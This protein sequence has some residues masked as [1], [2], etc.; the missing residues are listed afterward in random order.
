MLMTTKTV[1]LSMTPALTPIRRGTVVSTP[2][3]TKDVMTRT[4]PSYPE[5][6]SLQLS[7][8]TAYS[9]SELNVQSN[10]LP[11]FVPLNDY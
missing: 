1:Y 9:S 2:E 6:P 7:F 4:R 11:L 5:L 8:R 3:R 10:E